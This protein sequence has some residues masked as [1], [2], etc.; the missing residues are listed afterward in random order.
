M[1]STLLKQGLTSSEGAFCFALSK[2]SL[3]FVIRFVLPENPELLRLSATLPV[4]D[5]KGNA[6]REVPEH[7]EEYKNKSDGSFWLFCSCVACF[8]NIRFNN[9]KIKSGICIY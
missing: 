7:G 9:K 4:Q 3:P 5:T 8:F 1:L 2:L 6:Q